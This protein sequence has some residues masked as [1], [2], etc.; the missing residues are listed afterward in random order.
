MSRSKKKISEARH[1][2]FAEFR[3]GIEPLESRLLLTAVASGQAVAA[4]ISSSSQQDTYTFSAKAGG[5]IEASVGTPTTM[6]MKME[7]PKF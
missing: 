5:T 4:S 6:E 2:G 3:H 7:Y 1:L